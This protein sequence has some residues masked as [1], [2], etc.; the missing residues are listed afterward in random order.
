[1]KKSILLLSV[2][3]TFASCGGDDA[4]SDVEVA[5]P[6]SVEELQP[7]SIE[8]YVTATGTVKASMEVTVNAEVSGE[9]YLLTNPA[10]GRPFSLGDHV[11]KGTR[12]IRLENEEQENSIRVDANKLTL[13]SARL[14]FEQAKSLYEKG[15]ITRTEL[16]ASER[17]Y[18]D[19]KYSY[20]NALIQL[21]KLNITAAFDGLITS[22]PYYSRGVE[23]P[24]G[25]ELLGL[26]E[27]AGLQLEISLPGKEMGRAE[28]GQDVRIMNYTLPD[29]TLSGT[30]TQVSPAL[31][32]ASRSFKAMV[33]IDNPELL[34][35]PGMFVKAEIIVARSD[36]AIVI[37]KDVVQVKQ[38]GKTVFIVQKGAAQERIITTG[39]ENPGWIEVIE[40]LEPNERLVVRGFET[41]RNRSKV[42]VVR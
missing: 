2:L 39:L 36:S 23:V 41:L 25:S 8:E 21:E 16:T 1:M 3:L 37:P 24:Q 13:E 38:R 18:I 35:R 14:D 26:Q 34:L 31:D 20:E 4:G 40:G 5:V 42:K 28:A 12:I 32:A 17:A 10:T 22:L 15:G 33:E 30:V 6:V 29:D 27:Y 11:S 7:G 19:A 9:Y